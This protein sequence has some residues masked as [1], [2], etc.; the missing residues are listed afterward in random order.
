VDMVPAHRDEDL[1]FRELQ[2]MHGVPAYMRRVRRMEQAEHDLVQ[3]CR[4]QRD[5]W[6][7]MVRLR[8]ATL[9]A[10]AG[11]W[12][13]LAPFVADECQLDLLEQTHDELRPTLR[14]P[15]APTT[16]SRRLRQA[17]AE[18]CESL[19][20]FNHRWRTWVLAQDVSVVN[21]LREGYNRYYVLEKECALRSASVARHGF[22]RREPMRPEEL[23]ALVPELP[24][25]ALAGPR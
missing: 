14:C 1:L 22:V 13:A 3:R 8:L 25:P 18:L 21:E 11:G 12:A 5:D 20:R 17:L 24:V 9:R 23:L 19:E 4:K 10:L 16:S 6:L 2:S 15:V 7:M